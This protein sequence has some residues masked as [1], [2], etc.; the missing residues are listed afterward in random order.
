MQA[1]I[2]P[3]ANDENPPLEAVPVDPFTVNMT[4]SIMTPS[5]MNP[6]FLALLR[7][8]AVII[9][10]GMSRSCPHRVIEQPG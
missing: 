5:N 1:A 6:A 2:E 9:F 8:R 3:R 10:Y 7:L 4:P